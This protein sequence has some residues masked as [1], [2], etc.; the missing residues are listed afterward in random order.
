MTLI[1]GLKLTISLFSIISFGNFIW[2]MLFFFR[3]G[4]RN[5]AGIHWIKYAGATCLIT[6]FF[7]IFN[8]KNETAVLLFISIF[9]YATSLLIFWLSVKAHGKHRPKICYTCDAPDS[10]TTHGIYAFVRHPFYLS[11]SIAWCAGVIA[12]L[13][14]ILLITVIIMVILY[15]HAAL[16]EEKSFESTS[17]GDEFL[18][19]KRKTGM[20]IP[21]FFSK[22]RN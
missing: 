4:T 20:M 9:L 2:G 10:L 6:Q 19:Y 1:T 11:Y 18:K 15:V 22:R 8:N 17:Y 14:V 16:L 12:T 3:K 7:F 5:G 13:E 21:K